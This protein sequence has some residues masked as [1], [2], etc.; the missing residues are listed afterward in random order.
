MLLE[1]KNSEGKSKSNEKQ[2]SV[3]K[4]KIDKEPDLNGN[5]DSL[6]DNISI[7][8]NT[9]LLSNMSRQDSNMSRQG[10][11]LSRQYSEM[12][13]QDSSMSRQYNEMS[14]QDSSMSRQDS[15][16]SRQESLSVPQDI[17]PCHTPD[18]GIE[19]NMWD[20]LQE[21]RRVSHFDEITSTDLSWDYEWFESNRRFRNWQSRM[22]RKSHGLDRKSC[23]YDRA[24]CDQDTK[25]HDQD[26]N[27]LESNGNSCD[28]DRKLSDSWEQLEIT[29][30][31]MI[32]V[33]EESPFEHKTM[34]LELHDEL[35]SVNDDT[36][37]LIDNVDDD[38]GEEDGEKQ[39]NILQRVRSSFTKDY[40]SERAQ[41][42]RKYVKRLEREMWGM[43]GNPVIQ[44]LINE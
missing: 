41:Q 13:R 1:M 18:S 17:D 12:S 43:E 28:L 29:P 11:Y 31:V 9:S 3:K 21:S 24:S 6:P 36:Q 26:S 20:R 30:D 14:R 42:L 37:V 44:D 19:I 2:N 27:S 38:E 34:L 7:H 5:N 33:E 4:D 32:E 22:S 16:M 35:E 8:S 40:I 15:H 23:D 10:N 25:S 39:K